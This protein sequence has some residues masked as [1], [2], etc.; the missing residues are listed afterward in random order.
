MMDKKE[1][2]TRPQLL[3]DLVGVNQ[4]GDGALGSLKGTSPVLIADD[5]VG[6]VDVGVDNL[7][8]VLDFEGATVSPGVV[9]VGF[10]YGVDNLCGVE[11][12][13]G[14]TVPPGV[15]LVGFKYGVDNW[16]GIVERDGCGL[17]VATWLDNI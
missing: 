5:S 3:S 12:F 13:E 4:A 1:K 15:V 10:K 8:G 11:D 2:K 16:K 7:C 9:L 6:S 17:E 14:T